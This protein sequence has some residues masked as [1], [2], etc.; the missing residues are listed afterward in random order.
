MV[1]AARSFLLLMGSPL[2]LLS[3]GIM[4]EIAIGD[5]QQTDR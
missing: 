5:N 3:P 4:C 1:S 2:D